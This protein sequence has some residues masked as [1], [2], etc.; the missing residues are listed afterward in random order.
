MR[1]LAE[2]I[3]TVIPEDPFQLLFLGGVVCLVA[4]HGLKWWPAKLLSPEQTTS[5]LK[6]LVSY[7]GWFPV[8]FIIFSAVA[9][10]F[11]CFWPGK[12]PV[13]RIVGLVC[14][15][16][17]FGFVL[18]FSRV[19][20]LSA[21]QSSVLESTGSVLGH[22]LRRAET[23][24]WA[25]PTGF[26]C[27]LLGLLLIGV[28]TSRVAFG[29]SRLPLALPGEALVCQSQDSESWPRIQFLI[30]ALVGPY[31]LVGILLSFISIGIPFTLLSRPPAYLQSDWFGRLA[32]I[33][34]Y[35]VGFGV[36]VCLVWRKEKETI[37]RALRVPQPREILLAAAFAIGIDVL[38]SMGQYVPERV[39][40]AA[41]NFGRLGPP[42]LEAYFSFPEPWLF[43][44]LFAALCEELIFRGL[45]Q[46]RLIQRY[47]LYRGV[48]L[49][50]II[51]AAYHFFY[52][53][54]FLRSAHVN[55]FEKLGFRIFMCITLSFVLGWLTLRAGSVLPAAVA[56]GLY[57]VFSASSL[58][59]SFPGMT[60][61]RVGL[62]AVLAYVLFRFWPH[63][64]ED[65]AEPASEAQSLENAG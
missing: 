35:L 5:D 1:R 17:L 9:G 19:L 6:Q 53:F 28:F 31:F 4:A 56:H 7:A 33:L 57:N 51:W 44:T 62:W 30:F 41:Q 38:I 29:I 39:Q 50:G 25:L 23:L 55:V 36:L 65:F 34:E 59:P 18:L 22:S 64:A 37:K 32:T 26:Q 60:V 49:V 58:G 45:L 14:A 15:P 12:N 13:R 3:R 54:S 47:G 61:V 21:P 10:Y 63:K 27:T 42:R 24:L 11:V 8:Y 46:S 16:A 40:W 52:D 2:F 20:Y 43:L 48:F